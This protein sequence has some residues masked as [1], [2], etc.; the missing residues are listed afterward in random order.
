MNPRFVSAEYQGIVGTI[1]DSV[2]FREA[3]SDSDEKASVRKQMEVIKFAID[4]WPVI[5]TKL[6]SLWWAA[7]KPVSLRDLVYP[8]DKKGAS[9]EKAEGDFFESLLS[10]SG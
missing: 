6:G 1:F 8:A 3:T 10:R 5:S 2:E 7:T 4:H 9:S